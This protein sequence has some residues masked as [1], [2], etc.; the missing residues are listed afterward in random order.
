MSN[1]RVFDF[2]LVSLLIGGCTKT[3]QQ[4][5]AAYYPG[6]APTTQPVPK[7]AIYSIRFLDEKGKKT[8]GLID[9]HRYLGAGEHAGFDLDEDNGIVA[10]A[11]NEEFPI[12]IPPGYGAIWSATYQK[13]T[14]FAKEVSKAAKTTGKVA[15]YIAKGLVVRVVGDDDDD[16]DD[17]SNAETQRIYKH[18]ERQ[19]HLAEFRNHH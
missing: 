4:R 13:R 9:S 2:V 5:V 16:W 15:G 1:S 18:R 6:A 14:Q 17:S 3:I 7:A 10:V 12:T 8:G 19:K 11:G